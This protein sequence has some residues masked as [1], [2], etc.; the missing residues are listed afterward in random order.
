MSKEDNM[1]KRK[2]RSA[3][4]LFW[5]ILGYLMAGS[6][7]LIVGAIV[8]VFFYYNSIES[9]RPINQLGASLKAT[10]TQDPTLVAKA[11]QLDIDVTRLNLVLANSTEAGALADFAEPN[12]IDVNPGQG[13]RETFL[14]LAHEYYHYQWKEILTDNERLDIGNKL[15]EFYNGDQWLQKRMKPYDDQ[16]CKDDCFTNELHSVMCTEIP[17]YVI[18]DEFINYCN[19]VVPNRGL[20]VN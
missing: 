10:V 5:L 7:L 6:I 13:D 15:I 19:S 1:S 20:F 3:S 11:A 16:G 9:Q 18:T 2:R 17:S 8:G 4:D 12:T 14:S